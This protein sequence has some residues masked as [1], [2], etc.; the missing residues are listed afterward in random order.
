MER[1]LVT[2]TSPIRTVAV[3]GATSRVVD[4]ITVYD[5]VIAGYERLPVADDCDG[6]S[7]AIEGF[8]ADQGMRN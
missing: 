8:M 4:R 5:V 1:G 3:K 7:N 2:P 6:L